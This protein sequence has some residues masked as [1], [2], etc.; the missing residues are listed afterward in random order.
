VRCAGARGRRSATGALFGRIHA[1]GDG[2]RTARG[3]GEAVG[4]GGE[5]IGEDFGGDLAGVLDGDW[6]AQNWDNRHG[7]QSGKRYEFPVTLEVS[8][9][10][11][12]PIDTLLAATRP[13][14]VHGGRRAEVLR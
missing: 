11:V 14:V 10:Q 8:L 7:W 4:V 12:K 5:G 9:P 13:A 6:L 1:R 2:R 3:A